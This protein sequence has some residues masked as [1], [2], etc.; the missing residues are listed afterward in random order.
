MRLSDSPALYRFQHK[1]P[2]INPIRAKGIE[3][4]LEVSSPLLNIEGI[5]NAYR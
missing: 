4:I 1:T 5:T 2:V 3:I